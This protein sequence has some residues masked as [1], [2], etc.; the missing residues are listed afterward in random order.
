MTD[1]RSCSR[2]ELDG[3]RI[4]VELSDADLTRLTATAHRH[5]VD[6][7]RLVLEWIRRGVRGSAWARPDEWSDQA[8]R[9]DRDIEVAQQSESLFT[10]LLGDSRDP[11]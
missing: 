7:A 5:G 8:N 1:H 3:R 11:G 6:G 2:V 9:V 10:D 4:V